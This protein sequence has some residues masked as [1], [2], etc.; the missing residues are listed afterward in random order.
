MKKLFFPLLGILLLFAACS[1][2]EPVRNVEN[3][4]TASENRFY[5]VK[6]LE[7]TRGVAQRNKLWYPGTTIDIKFLNGAEENK[8]KVKEYASEWEK[9][10]NITF[11]FIDDGDAHVRIAFDSNDSRY[12]TW[13]TI[14][15]DCKMIANQSEPTINYVDW[16]YLSEEEIKGD[17]LR[18]FGQVLGLELEHR[19]LDFD[20][21]WR[22]NISLY[23]EGSIED[24]PWTELKKYVFDPLE[25][26]K[27]L[28]T[29]EYDE[30]SI[31]IWPFPRQFAVN[32]ARYYNNELSSKDIAFVAQVYP[33]EINND[34]SVVLAAEVKEHVSFSINGFS[35]VNDLLIDWGDGLQEYLSTYV[36]VGHDIFHT[37]V[38]DD[39]Y[40]I[41]IYGSENEIQ[42]IY[43]SAGYI[44]SFDVSGSKKLWELTINGEMESLDITN[45]N[46]ITTLSC[47]GNGLVNLNISEN[48]GLIRLYCNDNQLTS[49]DVSA[50]TELRYLNC[51][52]NPLS[53]LDLSGNKTLF[54]LNCNGSQLSSLDLWENTHLQ[55]LQCFNNQLTSLDLSGNPY[56]KKI[57]CSDNQLE[58]LTLADKPWLEQL[59]CARNRLTSLDLYR[60]QSIK[61]LSCGDN[62]LTSLDVSN[63]SYSLEHLAC[64]NN[65]ISNLNVSNNLMLKTLDCYSNRLTSLN[66]INNSHLYSVR[67]FNNNLTSLNVSGNSLVRTIDCYNNPFISDEQAVIDLTNSLPNC[68]GNI[69]RAGALN[70]GVLSDTILSTILPVATGKNWKV[71]IRN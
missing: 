2:D 35:Y 64:Y 69:Y 1:K 19:H 39:L 20:A 24:I 45:N 34:K 3:E 55:E 59:D 48:P 46:S 26:S 36:D 23:W 52:N 27:I 51:S 70:L 21:G 22:N 56:V 40:T 29:D 66:L 37:Y 38:G 54:E 33:K 6:T 4:K 9:Y 30:N 11:S 15:T 44:N 61:N 32:T 71:A 28:Q 63:N 5:G 10:A 58:I 47:A 49:L 14:G 31:M 7:E 25:S 12:V 18:T 16:E 53:S 17:V 42:Q 57:H 65:Q 8:Q 50:N 67:C 43:F 13:S 68:P 60:A 62:Q 41:K